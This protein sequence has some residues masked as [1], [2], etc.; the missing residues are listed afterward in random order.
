MRIGYARVSTDDQNLD[1][2]L[3][4]LEKA[5]CGRVY[6]E[7][8]SGKN[9]ERP[10]LR[11]ML[12]ALREGDTVIVY[13]LDRISRSVQDLESLAKTFSDMHVE[14]VSLQDQIDTTTAMGRFFFHVMSAVAELERD[15]IVERT[16]SGLEAARARGRVG[17][18]K[19]MDPKR[20]K[21]MLAMYDSGQMTVPEICEAVGVSKP[22]L[23]KYVNERKV[24]EKG[25]ESTDDGTGE[26]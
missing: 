15:I 3:D 19:P 14:F 13:K 23:Y 25:S 12:D 8:A 26:E 21:Q 10:E 24:K 7:H 6:Q 20:V 9:T 4:A 17:G 5:G 18:R 2:Q 22:T 16:K 1:M 11:K